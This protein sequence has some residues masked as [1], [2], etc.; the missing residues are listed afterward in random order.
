MSGLF[1]LDGD[2]IAGGAGAGAGV[3]CEFELLFEALCHDLRPAL[4]HVRQLILEPGDAS[5]FDGDLGIDQLL[6]CGLQVLLGEREALPVVLP[7]FTEV[8]ACAK[9]FVL[10]FRMA[11]HC[12]FE[13]VIITDGIY[14]SVKLDNAFLDGCLL[15]GSV[16]QLVEVEID[17]IG[18]VDLHPIDDLLPLI[19]ARFVAALLLERGTA[20]AGESLGRRQFAA[21]ILRRSCHQEDSRTDA[22]NGIDAFHSIYCPARAGSLMCGLKVQKISR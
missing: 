21:V 11:N 3:L 18:A 15:D 7:C 17:L 6:S 10:G 13:Q 4:G 20:L 8:D 16:F 2:C 9:D 12:L 14:L 22:D 5:L 19:F 1:G